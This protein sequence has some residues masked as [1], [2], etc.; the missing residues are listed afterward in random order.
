MV[1][2]VNHPPLMFKDCAIHRHLLRV[3]SKL[4]AEHVTFIHH[5]TYQSVMH[6]VRITPQRLARRCSVAKW[7]KVG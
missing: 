3:V 7:L 1:F 2:I 5:Y 4:D 6:V